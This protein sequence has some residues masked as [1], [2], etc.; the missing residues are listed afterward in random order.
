MPHRTL[1]RSEPVSL[2][3]LYLP[4]ELSRPAVSALGELATIQFR[5]LNS[6]VSAFQRSFVKEIRNVDEMERQL[7]YFG[8]Q[9]EKYGIQVK[10]VPQDAVNTRA[11]SSNEIDQLSEK[12]SQFEQRL[13]HLNESTET[14]EKRYV[15]LVELRHVLRET[16]VFFDRAHVQQDQIRSSTDVDT[17]PLLDNAA[18]IEQGDGLGDGQQYQRS[19]MTIGFVTG[20]I[21][22][23]RVNAFERILWRTL[24]GNLYMN[25]SEI[26]EPIVDPTTEEQIEKN[27]FIIFAHGPQILSKIRKIS[28]A[29][30][31]DLYEVD[32][33]PQERRRQVEEVNTR[34]D[35]IN[36]VLSNT[37]NTMYAELRMIAETL[38]SWLTIVKKEKAIYHTLNLFNYD[39]NRKTLIAEGWCPT[40]NLG[41]VQNALRD[42]TDHAG[43][44]VPIILNTL[45][46]TKTPPTF[47]RTNKFTSGFQSIIDSYGIATYR[48]VNPGLIAIVTFP[49]LF[50]IMFGDLGHG[51]IMFTAAF[52]LVWYEKSLARVDYGEIFGMAYYGR[53]IILLMGAFSMYTGLIYNDLFS[54]SML[55]WKSGWRWPEHFE[56][57]D[58]VSAHQVGVYPVG[59]DPAWHGTDNALLFTNSYKMKMSVILGVIHMTFSLCLSF[60]NH[61]FFKSP[62]DIW[63]NFIPSMLFLQSIFGYLVITIIYKW[64]VD[65]ST[66]D[67]A[68]PGLLNMLIY[69]FLSPGTVD[70]PLYSGQAAVQK[71][72][73]MI[74]LICVPWLLFLKPMY[75]RWEHNRARAAGYQGLPTTHGSQ[76]RVSAADDDDDELAGAVIS[77]EM[78][79]EEEFEFGEVMIH[80]VIHTIEFCLGCVSHTAS[81]L[82]LWALSLAHNQLSVVLWD[83]S[84]G[85]AL[86]MTGVTGVIA[87]VVMFTMWFVLTVAVLVVMEGTSAM[88][89][90]LRLH[91]VEAMSK[92]FEGNGY[93]FTPFS[94]EAIVDNREA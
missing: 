27:V 31:A 61:R 81:Y 49:F 35:D 1:F 47:H 74:A 71:I 85:N 63:A 91:W 46:T 53:Y 9:C 50:A 16:G 82:R 84:L 77:E 7:R 83:M 30:G 12:T 72:L 8:A 75:L 33:D 43:S 54:K 14:L 67:W 23:T 68:P 40:E 86:N 79:E 21:P 57:G 80:Q 28:E 89:H 87:L 20:V 55:I 24:R 29:L 69:M 26:D 34:L 88:L 92:H 62:L 44:Q 11:P 2:V 13:K 3:Q 25:Q 60:C 59:L 37:R 52:I 10:A 22:R 94:F 58:V 4:S 65:W 38:T 51:L 5:D 78:H 70:E 18:D 42:V 41:L 19:A 76:Q 32:E 36:A 17:A 90:S 64:C 66:T 6:E 39:Q 45:H 48:E 93:A 15:E 73:L 56:A